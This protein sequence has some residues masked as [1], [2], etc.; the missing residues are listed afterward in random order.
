ME[1]KKS[2]HTTFRP[3]G[4]GDCIWTEGFWAD[5]FKICEES[6]LPYMESLLC[7]DIGHA[8]NNFKIAAGLKKGVHKGMFW[9]DGDFYKFLEAAIYVYAQ[10]RDEKLLQQIDK[11]IN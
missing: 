10:N 8:L 1:N 11:T 3:I 6:M 5:K 2:T 7:G 9:H 4:I